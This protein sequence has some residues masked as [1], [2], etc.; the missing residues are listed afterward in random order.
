M[1]SVG[2][3]PVGLASD[4]TEPVDA[5]VA[6]VLLI[7]TTLLLIRVGALITDRPDARRLSTGP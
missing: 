4:M 6:S 2:N 3:D 1:R 5:V 7:V